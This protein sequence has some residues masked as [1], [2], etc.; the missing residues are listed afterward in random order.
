[1]NEFDKVF[2]KNPLWKC[3]MRFKDKGGAKYKPPAQPQLSEIGREAEEKLYGAVE[4]GL[5]GGGFFPFA[6]K[7]Y[8]ELKR[9]YGEA[10]QTAQ[11]ELGGRLE[12]LIPK[13]DV[14][15]R[16]HAKGMLSRGYYGGLD[17]LQRQKRAEEYGGQ[18]MAL[19]LG[20]QYLA[21]AKK[22]GVN[23]LDI[24]NQQQMANWAQQQ[25]YGTFTSNLASGLGS[26]GGYMAAANYAGRM[27][28]GGFGMGQQQATQSLWGTGSAFA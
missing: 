15:V 24:Y 28:G 17:E 9:G 6:G 10:Y 1:M 7:S 2:I 11:G 26:M 22:M 4:R 27:S 20:T 23:I 13:A 21:E 8:Q 19:T 14:G 12:R 25:Q 16:E 5:A 3:T 18:E